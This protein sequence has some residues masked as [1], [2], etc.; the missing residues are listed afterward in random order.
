MLYRSGPFNKSWVGETIAAP[1]GFGDAD[2]AGGSPFT[3]RQIRTRGSRVNDGI[4]AQHRNEGS[5]ALLPG[6][7]C[8]CPTPTE[9]V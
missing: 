4:L 7:V 5:R 3:R 1:F 2:G 8:H 6:G 9:A